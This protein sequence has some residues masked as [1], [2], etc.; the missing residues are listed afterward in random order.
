MLNSNLRPFSWNNPN[1]EYVKAF[2]A[3]V[4]VWSAEGHNAIKT[5]RIVSG[6]LSMLVGLEACG[7][8]AQYQGPRNVASSTTTVMLGMC[9]SGCDPV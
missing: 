9:T 7:D 8:H 4:T 6:Q 1:M 3:A 5:S 2:W